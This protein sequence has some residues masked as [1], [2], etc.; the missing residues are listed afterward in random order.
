VFVDA[1]ALIAI[2]AIEDGWQSLLTRLEGARKVFVSPLSVWEAT[3]GMAKQKRCPFEE[4][5]AIVRE[6]L[7][8]FDVKLVAIDDEIGQEALRA[9]RLYGKGRHKAALNFGDCFAYA[10]ARVLDVPLLFKGDD[11]ALTDIRP[12]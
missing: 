8:D 9:S 2:L 1:S 12:A 3:V 11:F 6:F 7:D 5:E 10:C 4:A